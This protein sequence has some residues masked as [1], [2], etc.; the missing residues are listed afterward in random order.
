M[1]KKGWLFKRLED[2]FDNKPFLLYEKVSVIAD[3]VG[4]TEILTEEDSGA[5]WEPLPVMGD[6]LT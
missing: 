4:F 2:P 5:T 6:I 3:K 1:I